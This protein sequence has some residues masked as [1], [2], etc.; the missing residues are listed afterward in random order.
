MYRLRV[1]VGPDHG[2]AFEL[3]PGDYVLGRG[4]DADLRLADESVSRRHAHLSVTGTGLTLVDLDSHNGSYVN[5]QAVTSGRAAEGD[6]LRFGD[7]RL[8]LER[9]EGPAKAT[10]SVRL[11]GPDRTEAEGAKRPAPQKAQPTQPPLPSDSRRL[12]ILYEV[13]NTINAAI[14]LD[15][16]LERVL[17]SL[18][19]V[20][21]AERGAL[22]LWE[23]DEQQ[24]RPAAVQARQGVSG[25]SDIAVSRA[26]MDEAFATG[27]P[28]YSPDA[29]ADPRFRS[30]DSIEALAIRSSICCPLIVRGERL[31]VLHLDSREPEAFT[32]EDVRLVG[33]I[34]NQA[35]IA[36]ANARL[37][38]TLRRENVT[39]RRALDS[40]YQMV[41]S[42]AAMRDVMRLVRRVSQTDTTVLLRGESGTGKEVAARTIHVLSARRSQP[43]VCVNC[44]AM[45]ETLL[46]SE[47]FGHEKG[48]FTGAVERRLGRFEMANGGTV[49]LDEI[50]EMAPG[51][52]AKLLRVLQEREFRRVGGT[53]PIRV[54]VRVIA[55]T[56]R[57]LEE[58][59]AAGDF[60]QDLYFRIKVVEVVLPP[61]RERLEDIPELCAHFLGQ[62]AGEMGRPTPEV[63]DET[64]ALLRR[65]RWPGN[66][67]ELRNVLER[68]MVLGVGDRLEP[69]HLPRELRHKSG[70]TGA[71]GE[72]LSLA[73]MER[74]HVGEV[75]DLTGW[76]KSRAADLLSISRPRL[77]RKIRDYDLQPPAE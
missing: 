76:N 74:R 70:D 5:G 34:G 23:D 15:A 71:I 54:D 73:G 68:A 65:H 6:E 77:D 59:I 30:S 28:I 13:G 40:E 63:S 45:P 20:V 10:V 4:T 52:Q 26:I 17:A 18:V 57:D 8:A 2:A 35:A 37:H 14:G 24:W 44:A 62:V 33:A 64:L 53:R 11:V 16:L 32:D 41:G 25:G 66:I 58:A 75:L 29:P 60:R 36:I 12:G 27:G 61:L 7:T 42:S 9:S 56:N 3:T 50:G 49:F 1:L 31:G 67:R 51:T 21:P 38:E 72:D 48:A 55:S 69:K 22:L 47:L 39:L 43:F 46:E 19:D